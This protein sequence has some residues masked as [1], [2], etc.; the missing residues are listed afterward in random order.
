MDTSDENARSATI[1][2]P[3]KQTFSHLGGKITKEDLAKTVQEIRQTYP[4]DI[5]IPYFLFNF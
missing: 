3:I 5:Y 1:I 4:N 2:S